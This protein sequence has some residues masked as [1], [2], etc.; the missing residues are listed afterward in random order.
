[1]KKVI[2]IS[3]AHLEAESPI[4]PSY[5]LAKKFIQNQKPDILILLGDMLD[6]SYISTYN[7]DKLLLLEGKR[8]QKDYDLLNKEL[9]FFQ[10][11]SKKQVY[12]SGNHEQR[13]ERVL[14]KQPH[15]LNM[16]E[17]Q[18]HLD[19]DKRNIEYITT[20]QQVEKPY[21]IGSLYFIHGIW[22]N[23][24]AAEKTLSRF[25]VNIIIGHTH[26]QQ[27]YSTTLLGESKEISCWN[28]GCLTNKL[29]DYNNASE[30][31]NG[32]GIAYIEKDMFSYYPI[33]INNAN[34]F[35][36]NNKLWKVK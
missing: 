33:H 32:F 18:N 29:P 30:H 14:E 34:Q 19:L 16:I 28:Q 5:K 31:Q 24:Y 10:K 22:F 27:K 26:R 4:H 6:F 20:K 9:D 35:F 23:K 7:K 21:C 3:D 8:F 12:L 15:L 36:F 13:I 11:Y 17:L 2:I 1:M 25:A